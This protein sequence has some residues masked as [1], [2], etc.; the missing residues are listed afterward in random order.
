MFS[1]FGFDYSGQAIIGKRAAIVELRRNDPLSLAVNVA[2]FT[3]PIY[4]HF[5]SGES[6]RCEIVTIN[7]SRRNNPLTLAVDIS[8]IMRIFTFGCLCRC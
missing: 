5:H 6:I 2:S 4:F 1:I 7:E 8:P 3:F